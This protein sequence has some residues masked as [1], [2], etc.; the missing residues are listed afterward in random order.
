MT[1]RSS[2]DWPSWIPLHVIAVDTISRGEA[3][4]SEGAEPEAII[5]A[6]S[7]SGIFPAVVLV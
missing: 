7:I 3:L 1:I 6:C 4:L 5:A 2:I